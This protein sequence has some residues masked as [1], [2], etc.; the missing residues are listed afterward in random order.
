MHL[1]S[2]SLQPPNVDFNKEE[3]RSR[4]SIHCSFVKVSES[5]SLLCSYSCEYINIKKV[6]VKTAPDPLSSSTTQLPPV[7]ILQ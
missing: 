7:S 1:H 6:N 5:F 3:K 4:R 2:L